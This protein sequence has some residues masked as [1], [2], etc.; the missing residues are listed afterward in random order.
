MIVQKHIEKKVLRDYFFIEGTIDID[1]SYFIKKIKEGFESGENRSHVT[2]VKGEMTNWLW[3]NKD[4]KF[5]EILNQLVSYIDSEIDLPEYHL[6]NSWGLGLK[7]NEKTK[8][9]NHEA[10][11]W[12]GVI[13]LNEHTQTLDFVDINKKV[14]PEKGKFVLFSSFLNH[15]ADHNPSSEIKW[16]ISFNIHEKLR[17]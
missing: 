11:L 9:H 7:K 4:P 1:V 6:F 5:L 8:D 14:K 15:E 2:N 3:F 10:A 12:A 17:D 13:Y 16:A